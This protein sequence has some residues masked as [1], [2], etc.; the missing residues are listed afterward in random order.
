M[1]F[2]KPDTGIGIPLGDTRQDA[3]QPAERAVT[4]SKRVKIITVMLI[5][6]IGT[7]VISSQLLIHNSIRLDEAQSLWQTSHSI[8]GILKVIAQDVHVPL[9]HILLHF[10]QITFGQSIEA[11]RTLSLLFFIATIPIVYLLARR[12]LSIN[13]SLFVVVLF[14]FSPFMNWY[15]NEARMY[16]LLV[17]V[18]TLSQLFFVKLIQSKG[19]QGWLGYCLTAIVGVYV[20]Y[21]FLFSLLTQA[22]FFLV[23][24]KYFIKGTFYRFAALAVFLVIELLPWLLYFHSLGSASNTSPNLQTPSS[25]DFFNVFSQ[26]SYGFQTNA[27]NTI[28]VSLWPLVVIVALLAVRKG[29]RVTHKLGYILAAALLPIIIAFIM[30]Y[31]ITPFFVSRYM[32]ASLPILIIVGVWFMSHYKK[33]LYLALSSLIIVMLIG[34]SLQEYLSHS[35]PVKEDFQSA[36]QVISHKVTSSDRVV[37]SAPFSI[38]PFNYYYNGEATVSTLPIWNRSTPGAMPAFD[39][40]QLAKQVNQLNANHQYIYLLLSSDQGYQEQIYQYYERHF[41]KTLSQQFSP[42]LQLQVYRVNYSQAKTV[43]EL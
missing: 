29:Q 3:V 4:I 18:T 27:V 7:L 35:T 32:I 5:S 17:L 42:G 28:L 8:P 33:P 40:K 15:A 10:W 14:S 19:R 34:T 2:F 36:A 6:L 41:E 30:S 20:H 31:A 16:T 9:Y 38:Y 39:S 43:G 37:L 23:S 21:F 1:K 13:W 22:I 24:R 25:I 12:I 11:A 26:F